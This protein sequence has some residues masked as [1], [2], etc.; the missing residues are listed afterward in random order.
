[1]DKN[2]VRDIKYYT[3]TFTNSGVFLSAKASEFINVY[4][5]TKRN[6]GGEEDKEFQDAI[7]D[8]Y[9]GLPNASKVLNTSIKDIWSICGENDGGPNLLN[10]ILSNGKFV[11]THKLLWP[12]DEYIY[13]GVTVILNTLDNIPGLYVKKSDIDALINS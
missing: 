3:A 4:E 12:Q 8:D 2:I 10:K 6:L 1:M 13:N 7:G 5:D 11:K 9:F